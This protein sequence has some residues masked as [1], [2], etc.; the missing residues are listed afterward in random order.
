MVGANLFPFPY[1]GT[2]AGSRKLSLQVA[3]YDNTRRPGTVPSAPPTT[4]RGD[5]LCFYFLMVDSIL[6]DSPADTHGRE[7]VRVRDVRQTV[8]PATELQVPQ[9]HARGHPGVLGQLPGVR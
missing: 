3:R 5:R 2:E 6:T 9:V 4:G 8:Q 7:A 1:H